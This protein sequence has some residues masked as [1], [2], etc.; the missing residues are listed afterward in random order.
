MP[1]LIQ[2][3]IINPKTG[4]C[5]YL[6]HRQGKQK[7]LLLEYSRRHNFLPY[8]CIYSRIPEDFCPALK[9]IESLKSL[10]NKEWACSFLT[11]K[12]VRMKI[13]RNENKAEKLINNGIPW[14]YPFLALMKNASK[15]RMANIISAELNKIR[16]EIKKISDPFKT[17]SEK[18]NSIRLDWEDRNPQE[19][20][21]DEIPNFILKF[22][23]GKSNP[24]KS[25]VSS[26]S[27]IS[28]V[29]IKSIINE[30]SAL[31]SHEDEFYINSLD[32]KYEDNESSLND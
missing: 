8:Y 14:S 6:N 21:I 30:Y 22:L 5:H 23:S 7:S 25:P 13:A 3:K 15:D 29:P 24:K 11:P 19:M 2:A 32:S 18:K 17:A 20:I 26:I 27:I 12:Q 10:N 16:I 28:S 9:N 4:T 1:L 31:P